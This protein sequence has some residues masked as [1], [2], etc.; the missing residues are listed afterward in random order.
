MLSAYQTWPV[1]K[2]WHGNPCTR[3]SMSRACMNYQSDIMKAD[4]GLGQADFVVGAVQAVLPLVALGF[5]V[6]ALGK[7]A[8]VT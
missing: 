1:P 4:Y 7:L 6:W 8:K 2:Y 5:G 3:A